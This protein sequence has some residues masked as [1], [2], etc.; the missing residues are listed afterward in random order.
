[1]EGGGRDS[2]LS[3]VWLAVASDKG[4]VRSLVNKTSISVYQFTCS[5][6]QPCSRFPLTN[7]LTR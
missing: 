4:K 6:P 2:L 3:G 7:K 5:V 1:M